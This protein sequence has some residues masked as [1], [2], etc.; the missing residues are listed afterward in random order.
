VKNITSQV[1][2]AAILGTITL[3]TQSGQVI[4]HMKIVLDT[5]T[6]AMPRQPTAAQ[7]EASR[8][9]GRR[10]S[11]P[12]TPEGKARS[13]QN[14]RRFGLRSTRLVL[15]GTEDAD[16]F[17]EIQAAVF[18]EFQPKGALEAGVCA[19]MVTAIWRSERAQQLERSHWCLLPEDVEADDPHWL[20]LTFQDDQQGRRPSL[21]TILRYLAECDQA[22][23]RALRDLIRLRR[24]RAG[25]GADDER[26]PPARPDEARSFDTNEP[27]PPLSHPDEMA[28]LA[29][30]PPA[31]AVEPEPPVLPTNEPEPV[32]AAKPEQAP[33]RPPRRRAR[34]QPTPAKDEATPSPVQPA[35]ISAGSAAATEGEQPTPAEPHPIR[36]AP[37]PATPA[38]AALL[39]LA[40]LRARIAERWPA[41]MH[42]VAEA[43]LLRHG[44]DGKGP[45]AWAKDLPPDARA[46]A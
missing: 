40:H 43:F 3:Q 15:I 34:A 21:P 27:E 10:S 1:G 26:A 46:A 35:A 8:A 17:A 41:P 14:A 7:A 36:Q 4:H 28:P 45:P 20:S 9:N 6:P 42:G 22:F 44:L 38:Q 2:P 31:A 18:D 33:P 30:P 23:A 39:E 11:G 12:T 24:A 5:E 37:P 13:A 25:A 29:L 32:P 16:W 19:R